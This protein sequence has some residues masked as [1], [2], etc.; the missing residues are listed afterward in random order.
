VL[1]FI[2]ALLLL[3][4]SLLWVFR[5][6]SVWPWD[7]A[8]YG[9]VTL[10]LYYLLRTDPSGWLY[11]MVHAFGAKAPGIAWL[12]QFFAPLGRLIGHR[13]PALLLSVLLCQAATLLVTFRIGRILAPETPEIAI[14][15][16]AFLAAAPLFVAMSHQYVVEPMQAFAISLV[17]LAA[18]EAPRI[19]RLAVI[20]LLITA[21]AIGMAA[22]VSTPL[23]ALLPGLLALSRIVRAES[24]MMPSRKWYAHIALALSVGLLALT[25]AWYLQNFTP[26]LRHVVQTSS[27]D[28]A[29]DYGHPDIFLHKLDYWIKSTWHAFGPYELLPAVFLLF[30]AGT[31]RRHLANALV[32]Q[33]H[34]VPL[35]AAALGQLFVVLGAFAM[36]VNE[37]TRYLLP[38][39]P[40]LAI[41]LMAGLRWLGFRSL[42]WLVLIILMSHFV[43]TYEQVWGALPSDANFSPWI[44]QP[45][46]E[47]A[48]YMRAAQAEAASCI[49][50]TRDRINVVAVEYPSLNANSLAFFSAQARLSRGFRCQYT[51]LGY[52]ET[53]VDRAVRR[54]FELQSP[55]IISVP[56]SL[57]PAPD[58]VNRVSLPFLQFLENS[59][60]IKAIPLPDGVRFLLFRNLKA[61]PS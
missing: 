35:V 2:F 29:L 48:D 53:D 37:E 1:P 34:E 51:S 8:W 40:V 16:T 45:V 58:F 26:M 23:Y 60:A 57:Q 46:L 12:G 39:G 5:D 25:A 30:V 15:G 10:D 19:P 38:L 17:F 20:A 3:L 55:F 22:K 61:Y 59:P 27:G 13:E 52:A 36:N 56:A 24:G 54:I 50:Q 33:N 41:L 18:A 11:L 4:P 43:R 21:A 14:A 9:E 6:R 49:P 28:V 32:W 47:P 7:Q 44:R 42:I 31:V